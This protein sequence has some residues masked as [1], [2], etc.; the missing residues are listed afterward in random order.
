MDNRQLK[1]NVYFLWRII[2]FYQEE[3][4]EKFFSGFEY[5]NLLGTFTA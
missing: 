5:N 3:A 4:I 2:L 1:Y